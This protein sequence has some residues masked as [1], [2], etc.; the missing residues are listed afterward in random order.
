MAGDVL[1]DVVRRW[2]YEAWAAMTPEEREPFMAPACLDRAHDGPVDRRFTGAGTP[3]RHVEPDRL[4]PAPRTLPGVQDPDPS[5]EDAV[6]ALEE[7][8]SG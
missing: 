7:G 8:H 2:L 5:Q 3:R 6:R 4:A 1:S